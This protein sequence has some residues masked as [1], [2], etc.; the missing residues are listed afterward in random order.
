MDLAN[1]SIWITIASVLATFDIVKATDKKGVVI[2][3][4]EEYSSGMLW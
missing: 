3:P 2:E 1:A 4:V